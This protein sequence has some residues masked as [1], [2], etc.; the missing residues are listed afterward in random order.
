MTPSL[1]S[2]QW[3][4]VARVCPR[5]RAQVQV[6]RQHW[7]GQRWYVLSDTGSGRQH[8]INEAAYQFIGRCDGQRS[9]HEVWSALLDAQNDTDAS[10]AFTA[11]SQDDVLALLGQ[12]SELDLLQSDRAGNT[13]ALAQRS[14]ERQKKRRRS[15]LNPFSFRLPLGDPQR[16]L[17][18]LDGLAQ[19]LFQP[20]VGLTWL[21]L[22]LGVLCWAASEWGSVR[23]Q[24]TQIH[25]GAPGV[26]LA[27]LIYPLMKALHELAHALAVRRWGGEVHE[28]GIGLL[29]LVPAPYVDA[30]AANAFPRRGQRAMVGAAGIL[31]E[32]SLAALAFCVW[33]GTQAG[34]VH[35]TAL[36]VMLVGA[37]STLLFNGN[38]LLRFD[39]YFVLCDALA[40]P[41]LA[42]RSSAWWSYHLGRWLLGAAAAELPA[43]ARSERK[44]LWAYAP[45]SWAYRIVL[46]LGLVLW[47]GG[48]W[49]WLGVAACVYM[50]VTVLLSPL[51]TW[52]QQA[53]A[54]AQPG[55]QLARLR[56][57]LALGAAA[58]A[59][60]LFAL[61]L[62]LSTVAPAVVWLPDQ[63]QVRPEV[64]GF[65]ADI[66]IA[67]GAPVKSGDLLIQLSN[68]ELQSQWEQLNSRLEGL[69]VEQFQQLLR[70]P[71]AAQNLVLD[72]ERLQ[73]Q[74]Q[75]LQERLQQL[76]LRAHVDGRL[77]LPQAKDLLGSYL[78]QGTT[79]GYVLA[80]DALRVRA[81]VSEAD[82]HLVRHRWQAA[83]VRLADEPEQVLTALRTGDVPAAT[84][85]LPSMALADV[86]GGS[87][88]SDPADK[89]GRHSLE[90]VFLLDL[91][92]P[93]HHLQ[94]VGGRAWVR[95]EH[96]TEPLA[97]QAY[98]R[99]SQ[100]FLQHFSPSA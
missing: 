67:D 57:R 10:A 90:P 64:D 92:L 97:L 13:Q 6:Q 50:V 28:A 95:I 61:P 58:L 51:M 25:L 72:I 17:V 75:R 45:M 91:S 77:S 80:P 53:M 62:P 46:S 4:R 74:V 84:H 81:A 63:A 82:A 15:M 16:A 98:R 71:N 69:Q 18:K 52:A 48:Q 2:T 5:L 38:P 27:V 9:V 99:A 3:Y 73:A 76:Q 23:A 66:L 26:L 59:L 35:N 65:I 68:P 100:L 49:L 78:H 54:H 7:R 30:S 56:L 39:A 29:F 85:L 33:L 32:L 21:L 86:G 88:A 14:V 93:G 1:F 40:L 20:G 22:M 31:V 24:A 36:A 19:R 8:R 43:H 41:N 55:A 79:V 96:G 11:P 37:G 94:R 89:E 83:S 42:Q 47:L 44:W 87:L 60:A 70:D 12:L 34:G